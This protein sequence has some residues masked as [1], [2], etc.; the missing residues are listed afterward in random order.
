MNQVYD[1]TWGSFAPE[2][3]HAFLPKLAKKALSSSMTCL[4]AEDRVMRKLDYA[5]TDPPDDA[6]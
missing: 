5:Q 2:F 3:P 4:K 6:A 1:A